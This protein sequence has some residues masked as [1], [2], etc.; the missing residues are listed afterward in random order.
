MRATKLIVRQRYQRIEADRKQPADFA[1][2]DLA[3]D[4]VGIDAGLRQFGRIDAPHLGHMGA[5]LRV[6]QIAAAGKLVALLAMFAPALAI[7]L[8]GNRGI[9][10]AFAANPAGGEH[11]VDRA[12]HILDA[13]AVMLDATR[14]Q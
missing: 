14:V 5:M 12:Q 13:M 7:G 1:S 3:E 4:F 2:V 8:A 6:G 9:A 10:A 11:D